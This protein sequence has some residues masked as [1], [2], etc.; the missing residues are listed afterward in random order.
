MSNR[1]S[2]IQHESFDYSGDAPFLVLNIKSQLEQPEKLLPH[3][4]EEME[5]VY[6]FVGKAVYQIDGETYFFQPGRMLIANSESIHSIVPDNGPD[7]AELLSMVLL[8]SAPFLEENLPDFH[9]IRFVN[10]EEPVCNEIAEIMEQLSEF[11]RWSEHGEFDQ[12][13]AKGLILQLLYLLCR[14]R[15]IQRSEVDSPRGIRR[16]ERLKSVLKFVEEHYTEPIL[17]SDVAKQNYFNPEY[18]SRYFKQQTGISFTQYLRQ[19]RVQ[20]A[21]KQ[22]LR[23]DQSV[24]Q[25]A[26]ENGFSDERGLIKAFR[27]QYGITPLQYRKK[28]LSPDTYS[29]KFSDHH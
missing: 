18:F 10:T 1:P 28:I 27:Q 3:W 22:L 21:R 11:V 2:A 24:L 5:I 20:M 23:S 12:L 26:L 13:Y 9:S 29:K 19:Y 17:L 15:S 16:S 25:I 6:S 14:D 8:L 7:H 4:H